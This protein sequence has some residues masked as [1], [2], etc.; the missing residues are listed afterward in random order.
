MAI[1][2]KFCPRCMN[3]IRKNDTVCSQCGFKVADIQKKKVEK[4]KEVIPSSDPTAVTNT[5]D[6]NIATD[7]G[8]VVDTRS[9]L[10]NAEINESSDLEQNEQPLPNETDEGFIQPEES[11]VENGSINLDMVGKVVFEDEKKPKRH[12]HKKKVKKE[13]LPNF[14]VDED[15]SYNIDTKDVTYLE[16]IEAPTQSI[17]K[18]RGDLP[19]EEK[20]KWWEIYKWADRMLAKRKITKEV[21]KAS[22]KIPVGISKPVMLTWCILFG[23]LGIHNFYAK[24]I[25]RGWTVVVFDVIISLVINIPILY[26]IMGVFVGGGLGFVVMA[27]W[28]YDLFSLIFNKYK[29]RI[30]KEEFIS[31]LNVET[32]AKLG[33]KYIALDK[34][35]FKE[36]EQ[37]RLEKL[38]N[39]KRRKNNN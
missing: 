11:I 6:E 22:H 2:N 3:I 32:R 23:W 5:Q 9:I 19:K 4:N 27:L 13:D 33:K 18:A 16:G 21:N 15:G 37:A 12:K 36:K 14:T 26:K 8:I 38:N 24:N 28:F 29:Y 20:L 35:V 10:N 1:K 39:K 34:S 30:S 7:G 17:R 31:N 25:K